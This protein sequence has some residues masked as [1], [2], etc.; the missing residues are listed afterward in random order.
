M[1]AR[2]VARIESN[3]TAKGCVA[4]QTSAILSS[5]VSLC[6]DHRASS[7]WKQRQRGNVKA[8]RWHAEEFAS[9]SRLDLILKLRDLTNSGLIWFVLNVI[10]A[11]WFGALDKPST[12]K[13]KQSSTAIDNQ[14]DEAAAA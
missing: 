7:G 14:V 3:S 13:A 4:A 9:G 8:V 11:T 12:A 1:I 2:L 5:H 10:S 6:C